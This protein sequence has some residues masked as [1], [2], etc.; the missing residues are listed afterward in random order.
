MDQKEAIKKINFKTQLTFFIFLVLMILICILKSALDLRS[1]PELYHIQFYFKYIQNSALL[2]FFENMFFGSLLF[3][4]TLY[5]IVILKSD[6]IVS[7]GKNL[8]FSQIVARGLYILILLTIIY[9][10][11]GE[12]WVPGFE[13]KLES[14]RNNTIRAKNLLDSANNHYDKSN[15]LQS[16]KNYEEYIKIIEDD[17][18]KIRIRELRVKL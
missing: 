4:S 17:D 7:K 6:Y 12:F 1:N 13:N 15:Y 8:F 11:A 10:V 14:L 3:F 16:L 2:T 9:F 18:I 5:S